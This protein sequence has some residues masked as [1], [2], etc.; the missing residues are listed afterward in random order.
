MHIR[1]SDAKHIH[2]IETESSTALFQRCNS[3][4]HADFWKSG[5]GGL[6]KMDLDNRIHLF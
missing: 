6:S 3:K 2:H 1:P 5:Y 4:I